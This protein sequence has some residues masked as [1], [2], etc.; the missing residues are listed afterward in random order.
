MRTLVIDNYDSFTHNLVHLLAEVNQEEPLVIANDSVD[1]REVSNWQFDNIV[2]SPGPGRP[3]RI[4]DFGICGEVIRNTKVPLLGICLGSQGIAFCNGGKIVPAP[5]PWHGRTSLVWHDGTGLFEAIP[6]PFLVA[7]YH[8]LIAQ[9][10]LP[11]ALIETALTEDKL[12]MGLAHLQRPQ[13]GLQF[14]PESILATHGAR[15]MANFRDMTRVLSSVHRVVMPAPHTPSF[16]PAPPIQPKSVAIWRE[17]GRAIDTEAA[18]LNLFAKA[19][20]AFWLD[21]SL[22]ER[23]RSRWSYLG[24]ADGEPIVYWTDRHR[25]NQADESNRQDLFKHLAFGLHGRPENPPPCPFLGG[26][27]GWF[28]YEFAAETR[29]QA[30]TPDAFFINADRFIAVDHQEGRSYV[31]A[32]ALKHE[33]EPARDW[34]LNT[35]LTIAS[36]P[37]LE[38]VEITPGAMPPFH[39][40]CG[41]EAYVKSLEQCLDYIAQGETYQICLTNE[42]ICEKTL[43]PFLLYRILRQLDPAPHA[44]FLR[45]REGAVLSASPESF[46][47]LSADGE[48]ETRPIK[49]TARRGKDAQQDQAS[50]ATLEQ[51]EKDRAENLM[52]VDLLR[53]DLSR[54]CVPG[55]V[56]AERLCE[57]ESY[58]NLHTFVSTVRG[59]LRPQR[60]LFDLIAATF[61]GGSMTGVPKRR[62][63]QLI[64]RLED[65]PRGIYSGA[66]GFLGHDGAANLSIVIRTIIAMNNELT[67]GVGGGIVAQSTPQGEFDE[68]LL[69]AQS[70]LRAIAACEALKNA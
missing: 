31:V 28:G 10:P 42:V 36:L 45:W 24:A 16:M 62:T 61:P 37:P 29:R 69:K 67:I 39:L 49:G 3:D 32:I 66:L 53:N 48:V 18:F 38:P 17:I 14:H 47:E 50:R 5:L 35:L 52:I 70:A 11:D 44:A 33:L 43:D 8:S 2:I 21:S 6:S 55:S 51:S 15:I 64:D 60:N 54:V 26:Y 4:E 25:L 1:W 13:W 30:K 23:G 46:L 41:R 40:R 68:M 20:A 56:K 34:V 63:L 57:I 7:R 9:R 58:A 22:V 19:P 65:R 59:R 12:V 27:V